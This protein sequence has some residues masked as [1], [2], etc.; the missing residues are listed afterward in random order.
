MSSTGVAYDRGVHA[1]LQLVS[2]GRPVYLPIEIRRL[3]WEWACPWVACARCARLFLNIQLMPFSRCFMRLC[4]VESAI[5]CACTD[6]AP[7]R[8]RTSDE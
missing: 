2:V 3:I 1:F 7:L 8:P 6:E 5:P 4:C